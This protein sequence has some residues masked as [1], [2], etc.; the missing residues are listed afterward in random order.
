MDNIQRDR[1][2]RFADYLLTVPDEQFNI[3][4]FYKVTNCGTVACA[5]GHLPGFDPERFKR[6]FDFT[7]DVNTHYRIRDS[8]TGFLSIGNIGLHYFGLAEDQCARLFFGEGYTQ[9]HVSAKDVSERLRGL[10]T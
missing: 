8:V 2:L 3:N 10:T 1:A 9:D 6:E 4:C 5:I 7:D